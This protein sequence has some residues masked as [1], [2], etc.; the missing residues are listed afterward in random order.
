MIFV[1]N[2][3]GGVSGLVVPLVTP[4]REDFSIDKIGIKVLCS[5]LLNQGIENFIVLGA[6]SEWQFL[7]SE[8]KDFALNCFKK[9]IGGKGKLIAGCFEETRDTIIERVNSA[10][11]LG[12]E[13]CLIN[14]PLMALSNDI[15][16]IDFFE[17]LF[18]HTSAKIYL[19]NDARLFRRGLSL[20]SLERVADWERL[21]GIIDASAN[22]TFFKELIGFRHS[23]NIFQTD[24]K[25]VF[26][27]L[28]L[29]CSGLCSPIANFDSSLFTNMFFELHRLSFNGMIRQ[30]KEINSI[31]E[32]LLF[33]VKRVQSL[34]LLLSMQGVIQE[35]HSPKMESLSFLERQRVKK[36]AKRYYNLE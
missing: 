32:E 9:E 4:L 18:S 7:T 3:K 34:K 15:Y 24:E 6:D 25:S 31:S 12:Y 26:E 1:L 16:F 36:F 35:Y 8:Q 33:D 23:L 21:L 17:Q 28:R 29:N 19:Y 20:Q 22:I 27:S 2:E 10:Q 11:R 5:R 14:I 30:Q 13:Y